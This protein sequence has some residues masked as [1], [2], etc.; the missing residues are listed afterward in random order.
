M[1]VLCNR[2]R[3]REALNVVTSVI[4]LKS[5]RP[6]AEN[7]LLL[8]SEQ[9]LELVGTDLEV[10]VR[11]SI[12]RA[13]GDDT[14]GGTGAVVRE[15]GT[16]L[17]TARIANDFVRDLV[18]ETVAIETTRES[19]CLISSGADRCELNMADAEEYPVV[20]RF[21]ETA[22]FRIPGNTFAKLVGRTAFAAAREPGRYAM[23]GIL[24]LVEEGALRLVATDGRRLA[25]THAAI[26]G[27]DGKRSGVQRAIVPTKG[28]QLFC[29]AIGD[30]EEP[31]Q[32]DFGQGEE[33]S[34]IGVKTAR[35]ELFAR[36]IQGEFPRYATV[37]P[38]NCEHVIEANTELMARKLR[39]VSNLSAT[40]MR[41]VKLSASKGQLGVS[42][43]SA[44]SGEASANLEVDYK[45]KGAEIAFN[46]DYVME[47]LKSCE[48][49]IVRLEF[50]EKN[51]PGKFKLGED[52]TYV[53]MPITIDA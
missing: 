44:A 36:L 33:Q 9:G 27:V 21:P 3:L 26:E 14:R 5:T 53:V 25:I 7:V 1:K 18:G 24:T 42:A 16:A 4:P 41:A 20:P 32:I 12:P 30:S 15:A 46:P 35:A 51:A 22:A 38:Q 34:Q 11:Y 10:S 17:I 28:M 49:E 37:I 47:G 19:H 13:D 48:G 31:I 23:H 43:R 29:R 40:D 8:A 2:E 6:A 52:Y 50:S 39:L 45:G